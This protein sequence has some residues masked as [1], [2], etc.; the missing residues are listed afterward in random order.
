MSENPM[1]PIQMS[2]QQIMDS[3]P[4]RS[5]QDTWKAADQSAD[6]ARSAISRTANDPTLSDQGKAAKIQEI[7]DRSS[8]RIAGQYQEARRKAESA[9]ESLEQFSIPM[10]DGAALPTSH[11]QEASEISA[12]NSEVMR[13]QRQLEETSLQGRT[14]SVSKNPRDKGVTSRESTAAALR[15][16]FKRAM[17][18]GGMHGRVL[19]H[20]VLEVSKT[21]GVDTDA[22]VDSFRTERHRKYLRDAE[23]LWSVRNS[24]PSGSDLSRN[25]YEGRGGASAV[26]MYGSRNR[27]IIGD[28]SNDTASLFKKKTR[29]P[30][31]K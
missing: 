8:D 11:L 10:P 3:C 16:E 5:F 25:P 18:L 20:A 1:Q 26:G 2:Y 4:D 31:W 12:L 19:A 15:S 22:L 7:I 30:S 9:V 29:R 13:L 23:R 21:S 24:I 6:F 17:E 27:A 14:K 28:G